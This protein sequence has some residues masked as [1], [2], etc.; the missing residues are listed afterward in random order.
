METEF[1]VDGAIS[2]MAAGVGWLCSVRD[3]RPFVSGDSK[4]VHERVVARHGGRESVDQRAAMT[5]GV[6]PRGEPSD[7]LSAGR[8]PLIVS[9]IYW[10]W[11]GLPATRSFPSDTT[12]WR[13]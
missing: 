4:P 9:F 10:P 2:A 13:G 6:A 3:S 11:R 8:P 12:T 1:L 7:P 5:P